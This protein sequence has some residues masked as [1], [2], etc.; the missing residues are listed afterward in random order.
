[1]YNEVSSISEITGANEIS[2]NEDFMQNK[3]IYTAN[4]SYGWPVKHKIHKKEYIIWRKLLRFIISG[5]KDK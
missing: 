3:R 5:R 2:R 4:S 1:M